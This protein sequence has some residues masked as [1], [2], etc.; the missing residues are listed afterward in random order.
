MNRNEQKNQQQH[1]EQCTL[2]MARSMAEIQLIEVLLCNFTMM[3]DNSHTFLH[4]SLALT[5]C[6]FLLEKSQNFEL[7]HFLL[8]VEILS[9]CE[10]DISETASQRQTEVKSVCTDVNALQK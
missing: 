10:M 6:H 5:L 1:D 7:V 8:L 2:Q 3:A 9:N 4:Y